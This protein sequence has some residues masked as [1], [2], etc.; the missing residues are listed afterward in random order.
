M[1]NYAASKGRMLKPGI[2]ARCPVRVARAAC[3][4]DGLVLV[5][6][7]EHAVGEGP[8]RDPG[9]PR[10]GVA[11]REAGPGGVGRTLRAPQLE[12]G[13]EPGERVIVSDP[14][15]AIEGMLITPVVDAQ[16]AAILREQATGEAVGR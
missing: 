13:V 4:E 15:P 10:Q 3:L 8:A 14:T 6:G 5:Q 12:Q 9:R 2:Q 1:L 11:G 16:W 7:T